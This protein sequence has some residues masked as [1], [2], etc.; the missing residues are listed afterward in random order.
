MSRLP[1]RQFSSHSLNVCGFVLVIL[2]RKEIFPLTVE[3]G[4]MW[5]G[6]PAK[7][8]MAFFIGIIRMTG[9]YSAYLKPLKDEASDGSWVLPGK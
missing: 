8:A 2:K 1:S 9:A 5:N 4:K 7:K 6:N 3:N